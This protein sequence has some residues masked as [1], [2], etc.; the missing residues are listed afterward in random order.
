M[1]WYTYLRVN[2]LG[3]GPSS[4][5]KIFTG[6]RSHKGWETVLDDVG[7]RTSLSGNRRRAVHTATD[8]ASVLWRFDFNWNPLHM[9]HEMY[10][11]FRRVRNSN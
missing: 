9:V 7:G 2:L 6:P 5:K 1:Q 3:P 11:K 4:Y 10:K 8:R